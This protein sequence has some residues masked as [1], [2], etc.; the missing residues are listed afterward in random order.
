MLNKINSILL[1]FGD[2]NKNYKINYYQP[3]KILSI[4]NEKSYNFKNNKINIKIHFYKIKKS[5]KLKNNVKYAWFKYKQVIL[6]I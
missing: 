6:V 1:N 3:N 4:I 2:Y 5:N